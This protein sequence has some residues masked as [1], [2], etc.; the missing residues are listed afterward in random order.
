[1]LSTNGRCTVNVTT[2]AK[3]LPRK[4][5]TPLRTCPF[6]Q[7]I[8]LELPKL[9]DSSDS[10]SETQFSLITKLWTTEQLQPLYTLPSL[11]KSLCSLNI[12]KHLL[13]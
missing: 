5:V 4:A 3:I 2:L 6:A 13:R 10:D 8:G 7:R 11:P 9:S 1:M 12:N